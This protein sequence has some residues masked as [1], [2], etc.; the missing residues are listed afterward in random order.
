MYL[1]EYK[2]NNIDAAV[3]SALNILPQ[4][5]FNSLKATL[6]ISNVDFTTSEVD[7]PEWSSL[8]LDNN[9]CIIAGVRHD[10]TVFVADL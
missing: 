1:S 2:G 7:N 6:Y 5:V 9:D 8:L 3:N 10:N 4:T